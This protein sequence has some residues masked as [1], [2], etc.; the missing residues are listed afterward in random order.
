M[1]WYDTVY[2]DMIYDI[3]YIMILWYRWIC[4]IHRDISRFTSGFQGGP[5]LSP[6]LSLRHQRSLATWDL[7]QL[8]FVE[9]EWCRTY[10]EYVMYVYVCMDCMESWEMK[11]EPLAV[12]AKL[13]ADLLEFCIAVGHLNINLGQ[14]FVKKTGLSV[15]TKPN[16]P[17]GRWGLFLKRS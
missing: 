6:R 2:D 14:C 15:C 9:N 11:W 17:M 16:L 8:V 5:R 3:W 7:P 10:M 4:M 1:I 13:P 12:F